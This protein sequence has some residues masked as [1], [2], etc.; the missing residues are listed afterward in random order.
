MWAWE[1]I[2]EELLKTAKTP[3][4]IAGPAFGNARARQRLR[5]FEEASGVPAVVMESPRGVNDPSLGL[6]AEAPGMERLDAPR[7]EPAVH[8]PRCNAVEP[9]LQGEAAV[10]EAGAIVG[11]PPLRHIGAQR[12]GHRLTDETRRRFGVLADQLGQAVRARGLA[13]HDEPGQHGESAGSGDQD[14]LEGGS[15]GSGVVVVVADQQVR[16]DRGELPEDEQP[17]EMVGGDHAQ[18]GAG[19]QGHQPGETADAGFGVP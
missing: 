15:P 10:A 17:D 4:L 5:E 18:H 12:P 8:E 1:K 9:A 2:P 16:R 13:Q 6:L 19:E 7:A 14:R 11:M 3:L